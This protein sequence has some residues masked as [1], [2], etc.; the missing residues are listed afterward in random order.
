[1]P[2]QELKDSPDPQPVCDNA[3]VVESMPAPQLIKVSNGDG[4]KEEQESTVAPM[5]S[6]SSFYRYLAITYTFF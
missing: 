2:T 4:I 6:K 3:Q 1:M 5:R